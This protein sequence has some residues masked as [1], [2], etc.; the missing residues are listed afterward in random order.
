[1]VDLEI[2]GGGGTTMG[3]GRFLRCQAG[4][5][6]ACGI[7][8]IYPP[9][10]PIC[11][12]EARDET[13]GAGQVEEWNPDPSPWANAVCGV[14]TREL[15]ADAGRCLR[16]GEVGG[17]ADGCRFCRQRHPDWRHIAVLST[18]AG[19]LREAVL[20]A[21]RP[22]GD[23][24]SAALASLLVRKHSAVIGSWGVDRVVPVPMHW[25]RRSIRGTSSAVELSRRIATLLG[26]PWS[27]PLVRQRATR[28]QNE[29]PIEDRPRNVQG[30]FRVRCRLDEE[31]ILLVDD[32]VTTGATLSA[33][34][35]TLRAAGA[36]AVDVAV[37]A[38]AD[39]SS[40]DA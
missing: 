14:C 3:W 6:A 2:R 36:A 8:L 26:V 39:R 12:R 30:A 35:R 19:G 9:R 32:V 40:A 1:M 4:R 24:V 5:W 23:E 34:C 28:M 20:R 13:G 37:V 15:S 7:D 11:Q 22:A 33:C 27:R 10:C 21:K 38:R 31:R 29:L 17:S 16:C 25:W 18:Y